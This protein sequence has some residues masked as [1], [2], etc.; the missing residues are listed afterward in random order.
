[1]RKIFPAT[2][3]ALQGFLGLNSIFFKETKSLKVTYAVIEIVHGVL[4]QEGVDFFIVESNTNG[5]VF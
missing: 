3:G 5:L 1:M 4:D 2:K